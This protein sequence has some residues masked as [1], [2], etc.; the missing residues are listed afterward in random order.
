MPKLVKN[1]YVNFNNINIS[2]ITGN[3]SKSTIQGNT[4]FY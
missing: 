1:Q 4:S 3:T 2:R